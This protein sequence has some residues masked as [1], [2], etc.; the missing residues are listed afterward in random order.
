MVIKEQ[1]TQATTTGVH[2]YI[3]VDISGSM[4]YTLDKLRQQLKNKLSTIIK[5][6]DKL[7]IIYFSGRNEYGTVLEG[8][9]INNPTALSNAH[10]AID[11]YLRPQGLTAFANPL[12]LGVDLAKKETTLKKVMVFF[13]DG[14][15]N[16]EPRENV[17][18]KLDAVNK[19]FDSVVFVEYGDY[20]D[21]KLI[22]QMAELTG[23]TVENAK[24]FDDLVISFERNLSKEITSSKIEI[25]IT[26][27]DELVFG[28]NT[29][30]EVVTYK[31]TDGKVLVNGDTVEI[32]GENLDTHD[33]SELRLLVLS[34]GFLQAGQ[35]E[36]TDFYLGQ[37][38]DVTLIKQNASAYGRDN[39]I[40]L[41]YSMLDAIKNPTL[42][43]KDGKNQNYITDPNAFCLMDLLQA[44]TNGNNYFYPKH[45]DFKYNMT[46]LARVSG[47]LTDA[48]KAH[49]ETLD[50][51]QELADYVA[52]IQPLSFVNETQKVSLDKLV[53]N[54]S[55]ANVSLNV[56]YF[57]HVVLP[58]NKWGLDKYQTRQ[59]RSYTIIKGGVVNVERLPVTLDNVTLQLCLDNDL[60]EKFVPDPSLD[61][62]VVLNLVDLPII[63]KNYISKLD[64][65][66][67]GQKVFELEK[68]KAVQKVFNFY[69]K[70]SNPKMLEE[71]EELNEW[72]KGLGLTTNGFAPKTVAAESMDVYYTPNL[73]VKIAG[74]S[75]LPSVDAVIAKKAKGS[76]L[77]LAD[78]LMLEAIDAYESVM[79][80]VNG[81]AATLK[82][83][84][85]KII[86]DKRAV[87]VEVAQMVMALILSRGWFMDKTDIDDVVT[88]IDL[89]KYGQTQFTFVYTDE[90]VKI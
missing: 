72:L 28:V 7:T 30:K 3:K 4:Y 44:L 18:S 47:V 69:N 39:Q 80:V 12:Q 82:V 40:K 83:M 23:G 13:T 43:F 84:T 6:G 17:M 31:V 70:Q 79:K 81:D 73:N 89:D 24:T 14:Y 2:Y 5:D 16:D 67:F 57:G 88:L 71:D 34:V 33:K 76:K 50:S 8:F 26:T 42:L 59:T 10:S 78:Q 1:A 53:F 66:A 20:T 15:S 9:E 58:K 86:T 11:R 54:S 48:Q 46:G 87:E 22:G 68:G 60:I 52:S 65:T 63:N 56:T 75:A 90:A 29:Q 37:L 85:D 38:G 74:L 61:N 19:T 36:K 32:F 64:S 35:N 21:S 77:N 25:P 45:E 49:I 27:D 62:I 51:I 41:K 55:K